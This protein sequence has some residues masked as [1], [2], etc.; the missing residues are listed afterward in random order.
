MVQQYAGLN[1]TD[2]EKNL[3]VEKVKNMTLNV[4]DFVPAITEGEDL[5][6]AWEKAWEFFNQYFFI[7]T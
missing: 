6:S 4:D 1:L 3:A 2:S 5:A 7:I